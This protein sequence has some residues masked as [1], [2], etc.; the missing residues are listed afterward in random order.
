[1]NKDNWVDGESWLAYQRAPVNNIRAAYHARG[2]L[3]EN[4]GAMGIL[5]NAA[6]DTAGAIPMDA[7]EK[8]DL[9]EQLAAY[10][11]DSGKVPWII[12]NL[13]LEW[14][15][16]SIDNPQNLGL[17]EEVKQDFY[18]LCD[19]AG[20]D[21]IL[22]GGENGTFENQKWAE[23]RMYENTTIPE[24]EE[25]IG[26]INSGFETDNKGWI[27]AGTYD[28]LNVFQENL[29][30]RGDA[31]NRMGSGLTRFLQ[32]GAID[33]EGYREELRRAGLVIGT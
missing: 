27:I 14:K 1:M 25:W 16:I 23:R 6:K 5:S 13:A 24:A 21:P 12:T 22:F 11:R 2:F 28:H 19:A 7:K 26:A 32:D 9:R 10:S 17:F 33:I 18:K 15:Q 20:V 29:K 8:T 30:E 4:R 31:L 3:I